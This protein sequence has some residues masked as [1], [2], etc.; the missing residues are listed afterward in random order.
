[1]RTILSEIA[2]KKKAATKEKKRAVVSGVPLTADQKKKFGGKQEGAG[3]HKLDIDA[4]SVYKLG[5]IHC[6]IPE[7]ASVLNCA[8]STIKDRFSADLH[9]GHQDGQMSLKRKM[10]KVALD[11]DGDTKMLIWLSKQRCGYKDV[12]PEEATQV[13][14]NVY[15]N[16][17]PR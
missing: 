4:E 16:E 15:T 17:V 10:H 1:M 7:V 6:T 12:Q 14:F 5:L 8:E 11:G 9:R 2:K 13:H 3:R